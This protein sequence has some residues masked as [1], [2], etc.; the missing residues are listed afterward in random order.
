M[1]QPSRW[2]L[3]AGSSR[4]LLPQ[5]T[6]QRLQQHPFS[7]H[8]HPVAYGHYLHAVGHRVRRSVHTDHL[9]I[10]CHQGAG[11]YQTEHHQGW[12]Q[13]GQV[14]LLR[15]GIAHSYQADT[16]QPWSIY[17]AHFAGD[18][19]DYYMD[20][21]GLSD[22]D[23][24]PVLTL[25]NWRALLPDVTQLLNLQHQRLTL[26]RALLAANLLQKMLI[27]M[28]LLRRQPKSSTP[29]FNLLTLERFMHDNSHRTLELADFAAFTGL[30]TF[31]FSKKFRQLTGESPIR[32]FNL[33]KMREAEAMLVETTYSV[34]QIS[35]TLGFEDPYYFSR[36]FKKIN[37]IAPRDYRLQ[38]HISKA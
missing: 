5:S 4:L 17:W 20:Y 16:Q 21:I 10:F 18:M 31:H 14:L 29:D 22:P 28:P 32:Y 7:R 25:S 36:L 2:P 19:V 11:R 8:L 38:H 24:S 12:L 30:S 33:M 23:D 27:Q 3:P 26:E 15:S 34:R 13:A 35:Q 37:G 6:I 9:L 1:S